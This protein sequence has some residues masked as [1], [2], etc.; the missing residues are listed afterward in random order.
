MDNEKKKRVRKESGWERTKAAHQKE[1]A[2]AAKS[3]KKIGSFFKPS[4]R[5]ISEQTV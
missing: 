4:K 5:F 2:E 1:L 3:S